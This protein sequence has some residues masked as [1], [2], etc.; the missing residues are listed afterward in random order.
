MLFGI[1][2][3]SLST[4]II[5]WAFVPTAMI[6]VAVAL[7]TFA[8]YRQVTEDLV[9]ERDQELTRLSAGQLTT[10]LAEYAD[11]LAHPLP[12]DITSNRNVGEYG[13]TGYSRFMGSQRQTYINIRS[14][15]NALRCGTCYR[16]PG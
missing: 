8:A 13:L 7:V 6:L 14:H 16:F 4:K 10:E 11:I 2:W 3:G 5:A 15:R 1:R 9:I 12:S